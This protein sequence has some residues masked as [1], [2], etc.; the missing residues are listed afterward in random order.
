MSISNE[1]ELLKLPNKLLFK[2][3]I[4]HGQLDWLETFKTFNS[5]CKIS[6]EALYQCSIPIIAELTIFYEVSHQ[7]SHANFSRYNIRIPVDT[8]F[9]RTSKRV[10]VCI[11]HD[12]CTDYILQLRRYDHTANPI[13]SLKGNKYNFTGAA[14]ENYISEC[15]LSTV[16][17]KHKLFVY[18]KP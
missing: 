7:V 2:L 4:L 5:L 11:F 8:W 14:F 12:N 15:L 9:K 1:N 16:D 17:G 3:I 18:L 10:A 13:L 6:K